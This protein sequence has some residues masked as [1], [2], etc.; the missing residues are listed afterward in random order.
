MNEVLHAKRSDIWTV[1]K[2]LLTVKNC[3]AFDWN[4]FNK[5]GNKEV[6]VV[7]YCFISKPE[8]YHD[9]LVIRESAIIQSMD[10]LME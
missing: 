6:E 7:Y 5:H 9:V 10:E 4:K 2:V 1:V 3:M 8:I